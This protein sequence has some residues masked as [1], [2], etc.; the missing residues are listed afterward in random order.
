MKTSNGE[1]SLSRRRFLGQTMAA[2][3]AFAIPWVVPAKALGRDGGTAASERITVGVIGFGPRCHDDLGAMLGEPDARVLA[4]CDCQASRREGGKAMVDNRYGNK[5]CVVYLDFHELLARKDIDAMLIVTGDRWHAPASIFAA[6]AG[7]DM[8]CEKPCAMTITEAQLLA[9]TIH[10]YGRVF[11][12]GTQRRSIDNFQLAVDLVRSGKLGRLKKL[13]ASLCHPEVRYD[14]LPAQPEPSKDIIDWDTWL[15][16][17]PWRPF[18]REYTNGGWRIHADLSSGANFTEWG[19]HTID[20]CQWANNSDDTAPVEY[21][22]GD[23]A[24]TARYKTGVELIMDYLPTPFGDRSPFYHT[25]LG[26]CPVRYEG[27]EGWVET[28]DSGEVMAYPDSLNADLQ[29]LKAAKRTAGTDSGTHIRNFLDCVK[30]RAKTN[31]NVDNTRHAHVTS[32]SAAAAWT[33]NRKLTLDPVTETFVGDEEANRLRSRA[34][35]AGWC[36]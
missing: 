16:P 17:C 29:K 24:M 18:N 25:R 7:K 8:Y 12:A 5:D 26:T 30:T 3:A 4:V 10:R 20:L 35:R 1:P 36:L 28:G 27:E 15:G 2:G 14:W 31:S 9:E 11:Q 33:L 34:Y 23:T 32:L 21:E 13:H 6:K 22:P 19:A